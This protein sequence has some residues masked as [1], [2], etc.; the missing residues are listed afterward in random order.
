[1]IITVTALVAINGGEETCIFIELSDGIHSETQ[2]YPLLTKQ[3]ATLRIKKGQLDTEKYEEIVNASTVAAAYKK[4]L[5]FLGYGSLSK[6][7]LGYKLKSR[8]FCDEVVS[9]AILMLSGDGYLNEDGSCVREAERCVAKLWGRKRIAS[10][11]YSKG[12]SQNAISEAF[13]ELSEVD[14]T[15]NC[16]KLILR[17]HKRSLAAAREDKAQMS[18]LIASLTRMGYSFFEIKSAL[19]DLLG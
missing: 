6:K 2:K 13:E 19:S 12:F 9:E 4:G 3:Y 16:K 15:E 8:G 5:T 18:K 1:M 14:Y 7:M 11:L 17:D 10:H